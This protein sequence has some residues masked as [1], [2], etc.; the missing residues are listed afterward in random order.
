M[1]KQQM[2][3]S[4]FQG[5]RENRFFQIAINSLIIIVVHLLFGFLFFLL[6]VLSRKKQQKRFQASSAGKNGQRANISSCSHCHLCT[7]DECIDHN[8]PWQS[9]CSL[10]VLNLLPAQNV[11]LDPKLDPSLVS[12]SLGAY[13]YHHH[14]FHYYYHYYYYYCYCYSYHYCYYICQH[15]SCK[16]KPCSIP[17]HCSLS[18]FKGGLYKRTATF[19]SGRQ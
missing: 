18:V 11:I 4:A 2:F 5:I 15:L 8:R 14:H 12:D 17:A 13:Y 6:E 1:A 19:Y 3:L 16:E 9:M 10:D 7:S